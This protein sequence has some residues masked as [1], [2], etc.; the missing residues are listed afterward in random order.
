MATNFKEYVVQEM[1]KYLSSDYKARIRRELRKE[2][3][4]EVDV[5][6]C[7]I[8]DSFFFVDG[9]TQPSGYVNKSSQQHFWECGDCEC[10]A[11]E[12]C[13][14]KMDRCHSKLCK[15][16]LC[17]ACKECDAVCPEKLCEYYKSVGML[18]PLG[19]ELCEIV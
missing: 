19:C 13:Y 8:C 12:D 10:I 14:E 5:F 6:Y 18:C 11:C 17:P 7:V 1:I 4:S 3:A 2:A 15:G 16:K 9:N